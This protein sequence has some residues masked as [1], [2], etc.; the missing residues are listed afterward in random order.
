MTDVIEHGADNDSAA[1]GL[2]ERQLRA[3][4]AQARAEGLQLTGEGGLL[5]K[6]TKLVVESALEG[7]MDD[8]LD[9]AKCTEQSFDASFAVHAD[10]QQPA[11]PHRAG[12]AQQ[13][14]EP[15]QVAQQLSE[16]RKHVRGNWFGDHSG[17]PCCCWVR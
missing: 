15:H 12:D 7:E 8:H 13:Q 11:D 14:H 6:L 17:P 4:V 9:Y 5:G 2:D 3:L 10:R 1:A 16:R